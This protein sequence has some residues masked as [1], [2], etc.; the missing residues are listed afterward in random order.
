MFFKLQR[1]SDHHA[2]A[3]KPYQILESFPESPML[4]HGYSV[5]LVLSLFPPLWR[6][7][8]DPLALAANKSEKVQEEIRQ[9]QNKWIFGTLAAVAV[10]LSYIN[11]F[12][13]GFNK[14]M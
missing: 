11:F 3:Y 7:I 10:V 8:I 2:Y 12:V 1:H 13:V 6:K 4:P 9:S 14:K 5:S